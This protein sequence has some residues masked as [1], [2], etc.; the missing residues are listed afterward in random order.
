V[1][2]RRGGSRTQRCLVIAPDAHALP[3]HAVSAAEP[4]VHQLRLICRRHV[5]VT[6]GARLL[7][8]PSQ[9][10]KAPQRASTLKPPTRKAWNNAIM[11]TY[12]QRGDI[13]HTTA[14]G[15]PPPPSFLFVSPSPPSVPPPDTGRHTAAQS[16]LH[17]ESKAQRGK[18]GTICIKHAKM[19]P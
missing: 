16:R 1:R 14:C 9:T 12:S 5:V 18:E 11:M 10:D 17:K 13:P 4:T 3:V 6:D 2:R 15:P 7:L 8:R 19:R